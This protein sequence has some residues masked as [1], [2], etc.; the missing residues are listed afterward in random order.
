MAG[1]DLD[2]ARGGMPNIAEKMN[3]ALSQIGG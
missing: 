2:A 3:A 1:V